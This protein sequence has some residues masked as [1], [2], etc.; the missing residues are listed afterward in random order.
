MNI[1]IRITN[2]IKKH[3]MQTYPCYLGIFLVFPIFIISTF[4]ILIDPYF[5][6]NS[7]RIEKINK[8]KVASQNTTRSSKPLRFILLKPKNIVIGSS[9]AEVGIDPSYKKW[10]DGKGYNFSFGGGHLSEAKSVFEFAIKYGIDEAILVTDFVR[11]LPKQDQNKVN[12][13]GLKNNPFSHFGNSQFLLNW[14]NVIFSPSVIRDSFITLISQNTNHDFAKSKHFVQSNGSR[15]PY[16][17][18]S[19][20]FRNG[21]YEYAFKS[22]L[23]NRIEIYKENL[24]YL[25]SSYKKRLPGISYYL[26]ILELAHK[27]N[28]K[29]R[30]IIPPIHATAHLT[31][32][33]S[34]QYNLYQNWKKLLLDKNIKLAANFKNSSFPI[35]DFGLINKYSMEE[36]PSNS[37][38]QKMIWF[39]DAFHFTKVYGDKIMNFI[40]NENEE[41]NNNFGYKLDKNLIRFYSKV[42]LKKLQ[43]LKKQNKF[44]SI[45]DKITIYNKES[46]S[47]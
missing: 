46:C 19:S 30:I 3:S 31:L 47:K 4:N 8:W 12:I 11:F 1:F 20:I 15:V 35:Y 22:G 21:G 36:I 41:L 33:R 5:I 45:L 40:F 16:Y 43:F 10:M 18:L 44:N 24:C 6:F 26:E 32:F 29:L 37:K 13:S 14:F 34:D 25:D 7:R 42:N 39:G 27:N 17:Q 23:N 28:I 2:R 38:S 9:T